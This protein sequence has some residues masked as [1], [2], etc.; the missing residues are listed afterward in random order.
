MQRFFI[1]NV[2]LFI[3]SEGNKPRGRKTKQ[4]D[5]ERTKSFG[6]VL[7]NSF[8]ELRETFKAFFKAPKALG[9]INVPYVLEGSVY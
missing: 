1:K 3:N 6:K 7:N 5:V 8:K 9:G 2:E 4:S